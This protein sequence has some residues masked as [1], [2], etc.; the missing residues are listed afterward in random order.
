MPETQTLALSDIAV[1]KNRLRTLRDENVTALAESMADQGLLQPI[2]VRPQKSG[3]YLLVAGLHRLEAA[4]KCKWKEISCTVFDDMEADQAELIEIDENLIRSD[5]SP[6]EEAMHLTRRKELYEKVHGKSKA[7][8]AR[9]ANKKMGKTTDPTDNLSD[10]FTTDLAKKTGQTARNVRRKVAR[11]KNVAVLSGIVGTSLDK[12]CQIDALAKL[13]A[14]KQ[15]SLAEAAKRGEK[16]S[17]I[18]SARSACDLEY[19][20]I[21]DGTE[22]IELGKVIARVRRAQPHNKDTMLICDALE[23][24]LHRQRR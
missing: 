4:K 19:P 18:P 14:E 17:A 10:A 15:R 16:V 12:G 9:A 20:K 24:R 1:A 11:S 13:P 5:L 7:K 2:V 3:G 21:S 22:E 6:A 23:R 8:G